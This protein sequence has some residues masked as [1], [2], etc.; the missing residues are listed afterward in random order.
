MIN[1]LL[2]SMRTL[3]AW[4]PEVGQLGHDCC[5]DLPVA[6]RLRSATR[7]GRRLRSGG[8]GSDSTGRRAG[9]ILYL[10]PLEDDD[11]LAI[12]IYVVSY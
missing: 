4:K 1:H 12:L 8:G 3:R 11:K 6:V 9:W 7:L 5:D 10:L 2:A